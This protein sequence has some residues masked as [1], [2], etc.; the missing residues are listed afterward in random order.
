MKFKP[1]STF[2]K[3]CQDYPNRLVLLEIRDPGKNALFD[4]SKGK[5]YVTM[6]HWHP[7]LNDPAL[8]RQKPTLPGVWTAVG[9]DWDQDEFVQNE[10][11]SPVGWAELPKTGRRT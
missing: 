9:W 6:G 7:D 5:T 1:M 8:G 3:N 11:V 2:K 10:S 4:V